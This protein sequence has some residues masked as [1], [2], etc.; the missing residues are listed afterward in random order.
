MNL[1]W[2]TKIRGLDYYFDQ[3]DTRIYVRDLAH[4]GPL[5]IREAA[6]RGIKIY[7][8]RATRRSDKVKWLWHYSKGKRD[9]PTVLKIQLSNNCWLLDYTLFDPNE[10]V[11][12]E[13]MEPVVRIL[14]EQYNDPI[15]GCH[16]IKQLVRPGIANLVDLK[17]GIETENYD[18]FQQA[19]RGGANCVLNYDLIPYETHIDYHQMYA[20]VMTHFDFPALNP[21]LESGYYPH[22][23]AIYRILSGKAQLKENGYP[24]LASKCGSRMAGA[25]GEVFDIAIELGCLS[26]PDLKLLFKHYNVYSLTISETLYYNITFKGENEF[27]N[28]TQELYKGRQGSTGALKRFYKLMNEYMAGYFERSMKTGLRW[29]TFDKPDSSKLQVSRKNPKVGIFILAYARQMLD[30]LLDMLPRE[31][32]I[33]YDTDAVFFAGTPEEIP[34]IIHRHC[35]PN[36]GQFHFDAILKDVTHVASKH[37]YGYDLE[38]QENF[39]KCSGVSK[40]GKIRK[41]NQDKLEYEFKEVQYEKR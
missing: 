9:C 21:K 4:Q 2:H 41:W 12:E 24:M 26:D 32:V 27:Q 34:Q 22:P 16:V 33:G 8:Y 25:N 18:M 14:H 1:L 3:P 28:V 7:H 10:E 5:L 17:P 15:T 35:G 30:R 13:E 37:Y 11:T 39:H 29:T 40:S 31:K 23:F 20:Y 38:T 6:E 19:M 36:M